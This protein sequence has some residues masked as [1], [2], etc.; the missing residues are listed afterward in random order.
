MSQVVE[1][2]TPAV[3]STPGSQL[4]SV[5]LPI[6]PNQHIIVA[7]GPVER[8]PR[9][10]LTVTWRQRFVASPKS[11]TNGR[12]FPALRRH[13][14]SSAGYCL[15][16]GATEGVPRPPVN[17][18]GAGDQ[19]PAPPRRAVGREFAGRHC[20][21]RRVYLAH[22][23]H[24]SDESIVDSGLRASVH[25][26]QAVVSG[27]SGVPTRARSF[28]SLTGGSGNPAIITGNAS[29]AS[30]ALLCLSGE[31]RLMLKFFRRVRSWRQLRCR[32]V[33]HVKP[34]I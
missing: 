18:D 4:T 20:Q 28:A 3:R 11:L 31:C 15:R 32:H 1:I 22:C 30:H 27:R 24:A 21:A 26:E 9:R 14:P 13:R 16:L 8:T 19:S 33:A 25:I 6:A 2:W 34:I 17:A 29:G 12:M 7:N 5:D 23:Q 10:R